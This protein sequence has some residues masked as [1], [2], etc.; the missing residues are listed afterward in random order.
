MAEPLDEVEKEGRQKSGESQEGKSEDTC[1]NAEETV[2]EEGDK[3]GHD[4]ESN[5][6]LAGFGFGHDLLPV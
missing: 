6:D 1:E 5:D 3:E 2:G 4:P